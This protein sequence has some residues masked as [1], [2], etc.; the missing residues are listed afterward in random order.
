MFL[1]KSQGR[2]RTPPV[3]HDDD[4]VIAE[5]KPKRAPRPVLSPEEEAARVALI[6]SREARKDGMLRALEALSPSGRTETDPPLRVDSMLD[7]SKAN[8]TP[9]LRLSRASGQGN[10][11]SS[12][13]AVERSYDG[14]HGGEDLGTYVV[15]YTEFADAQGF[16]CRTRGVAIRRNEMRAVAECLLALADRLN[17]SEKEADSLPLE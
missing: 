8:V 10:P 3:L 15:V 13:V 5:Q 1:K 16:R 11:G 12:L 14:D 4:G 9:I 17:S 2:K 6:A 7:V